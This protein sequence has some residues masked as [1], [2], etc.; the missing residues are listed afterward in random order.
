MKPQF[1]SWL[2]S[3]GARLVIL[4]DRDARRYAERLGLPFTGTVG[5][6]LEAKERG[7]V[8]AVK[9]LLDVLLENGLRLSLSLISDALQQAG[10]TP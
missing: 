6:L 8:D 4:D 2:K 7:F 10:E 9:P 3:A 5:I 1:L